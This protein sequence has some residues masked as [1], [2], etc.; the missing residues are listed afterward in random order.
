MGKAMIVTDA[1]ASDHIENR[2]TG[3]LTPAGGTQALRQAIQELM[4]HPQVARGIGV[5]RYQWS[6]KPLVDCNVFYAGQYY[7]GHD[8]PQVSVNDGRDDSGQHAASE[9]ELQ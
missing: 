5:I 4:E 7:R 3:I 8:C 2:V 9:L 1:Q 6:P